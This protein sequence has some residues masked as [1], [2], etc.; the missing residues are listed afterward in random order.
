MTTF[1]Q[2]LDQFLEVPNYEE[3]T[4]DDT[5]DL[6]IDMKREEQYFEPQ[7]NI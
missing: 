7:P 2:A 5:I 3:E 6:K 1:E 4:E